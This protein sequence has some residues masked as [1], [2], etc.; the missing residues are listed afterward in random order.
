M[1]PSANVE[2]AY[3]VSGQRHAV[4][5]FFPIASNTCC[6]YLTPFVLGI[7]CAIAVVVK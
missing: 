1:S 2:R 5:E 6:G 4:K 3:S 7:V